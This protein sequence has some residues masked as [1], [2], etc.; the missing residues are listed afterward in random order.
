MDNRR[1]DLREL[2][3]SALEK[4]IGLRQSLVA[5][6]V[7]RLRRAGSDATPAEVIAVLEKQYLR[8]A[9]GTGAAVGGVAAAPCSPSCSVIVAP[10]W[11]RRWP[12]DQVSTG[13]TGCRS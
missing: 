6:Y 4:A 10:S 5:G 9:T 2:L 12:A 3:R 13:Q 1:A 8:A 7:A 11:W